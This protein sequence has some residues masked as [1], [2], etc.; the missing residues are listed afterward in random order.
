M[1][2]IGNVLIDCG[3]KKCRVLQYH[4]LGLGK[5]ERLGREYPMPKDC[6]VVTN[7]DMKEHVELL[8]KMGLKCWQE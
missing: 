1:K 2:A 6:G 3:V 8:T 5:Y 7:E 4:Q